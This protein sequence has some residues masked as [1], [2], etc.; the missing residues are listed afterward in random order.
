MEEQV[1]PLAIWEINMPDN[2]A[3][4]LT[5]EQFQLPVLALLLLLLPELE[6]RNKNPLQRIP[7]I[8]SFSTG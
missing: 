6:A 3:N 7:R 4:H 2:Y 8:E 1:N 5:R